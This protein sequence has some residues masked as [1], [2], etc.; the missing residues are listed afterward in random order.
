MPPA[1]DSHW[2]SPHPHPWAGKPEGTDPEARGHRAQMRQAI[3]VSSQVCRGGRERWRAALREGWSRSN[4][5]GSGHLPTRVSAQSSHEQ[6]KR[7]SSQSDFIRCHPPFCEW[8]CHP[9]CPHPGSSLTLH[10]AFTGD[11]TLERILIP[12]L[13]PPPVSQISGTP[14]HIL[15]EL[16]LTSHYGQAAPGFPA[17]VP[18]TPAFQTSKDV[19]SAPAAFH[20]SDFTPAVTSPGRPASSLPQL[21]VL[22]EVAPYLGSLSYPYF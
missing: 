14:V 17:R 4:T 9:R 22:G 18:P 8:H 11:F 19:S 3:G 7:H 16:L 5:C 1:G 6:C 12:P 10:S 20:L 15:S 2:L 13:G 21:L